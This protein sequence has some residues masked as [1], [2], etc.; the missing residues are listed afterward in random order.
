MQPAEKITHDWYD[1]DNGV[2]FARVGYAPCRLALR[3]PNG[4]G[5]PMLVDIAGAVVHPWE[6]ELLRWPPEVEAQ[7]RR[8]GYL[9]IQPV[10]MEL[11][12]NCAD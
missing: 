7:L 8:G 6:A 5:K 9:P 11:W 12:C 2:I 1:T 4:V 3:I 10:E